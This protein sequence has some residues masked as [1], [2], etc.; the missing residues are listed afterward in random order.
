[1]KLL[2]DACYETFSLRAVTFCSNIW[3]TWQKQSEIFL[4]YLNTREV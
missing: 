3:K 2:N 4:K 1:M